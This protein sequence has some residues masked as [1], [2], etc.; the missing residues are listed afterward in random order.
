MPPRRIPLAKPCFDEVE[1]RLV[2][3]V[4]RSGWVAQGPRVGELEHLFAEKTG[5]AEAVAVTSCTAGLFLVLHALGIGLG[6]EVLVP[7]LSFIASANAIVH[8]GATPVFVD[9]EPRTYN[10]DPDGLA[11]AVTSRTRA[12]M[13]VHQLGLPCDLDRVTAFA[14]THGLLVVEDAACAAGATYKGRPIGNA[15]SPAVFSFHARKVI[16]SGEGG[17]VT[18][19]DATLA[20]RLRR[21]RHQGMSLS[22]LERHQADRVII[23]EYPEVGW[24][25][26]M[27]DLVA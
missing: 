25:F 19:G 3:E 10:I 4:L 15:E 18:T 2:C 23:E 26:R 24:N 14:R 12:I 22:D 17:I 13:V 9:V 20:A 27:P 11:A 8:C 6:D 5:A 7:S 16:T 21:L 1:E